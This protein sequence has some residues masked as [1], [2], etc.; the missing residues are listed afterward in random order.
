MAGSLWNSSDPARWQAQLDG[1]WAA[2]QGVDGSSKRK[3]GLLAL[4]RQAPAQPV[5][6]SLD[7]RPA[8]G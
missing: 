3:E 1:Y 5:C 6:S 2:V 8:V 7:G 4:D